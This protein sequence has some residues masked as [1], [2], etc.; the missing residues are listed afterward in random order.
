[1]LV[2]GAGGAL[3]AGGF[4]AGREGDGPAPGR[5]AAGSQVAGV[6]PV[7]EGAGGHADPLG[8]LAR[9]QL[10][11]FQQTGVRDVVVAA[12]VSGGDTVEGLPGA[13]AVP[14]VVQR[15]GEGVVVQARADPA[16]ELDRRRVSDAQLDGAA[17]P[18]DAELLAGAGLPAQPD[19]D[20]SG[21]C[22]GGGYGDVG[23]QG[24]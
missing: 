22:G 19:R 9:G 20:L 14:G 3:A 7:V 8:G 1:M 21:V 18:G 16:G 2:G 13:G 24:A 15:C 5:A 17:A 12:Q 4:H 23:Q 10:A 6:D 11:V